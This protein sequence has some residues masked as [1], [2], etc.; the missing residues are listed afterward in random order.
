MYDLKSCPFCGGEAKFSSSGGDDER[1]G[2]TE[3]YYVYC[4]SCYV[5]GVTSNYKPFNGENQESVKLIA[6][7]N[8]NKRV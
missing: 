4:S 5:R 8:W 1:D 2:Y 7:N 3:T 6:I